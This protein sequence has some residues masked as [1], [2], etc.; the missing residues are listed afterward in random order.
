VPPT[1]LPFTSLAP[2]QTRHLPTRLVNM[3]SP[4]QEQGLSLPQEGEKLR[5]LGDVAS[6]NKDPRVQKALKRL[7]AAKAPTSLSQLVMWRV[8]TDLDWSAIAELSQ[9]WANR[10]ELAMAKDFVDHLDGLTDGEAGRLLLEVQ[11]TDAASNAMAT[12]FTAAL[13]GKMVLG[14]VTTIGIPE[15]PAGPAL[16][17]RVKLTATEASVQVTG[18]DRTARN[19]VAF[20]KFTQPTVV[21]NGKLDQVKLADSLAE[22]ILNRVVRA[23]VIKGSAQKDKGKLVYQIRI[24]NASPLILNGVAFVGTASAPDEMPKLLSGIAIPPGRSMLVPTP[25]ESVK[26]L[27]LKKGIKVL[28]LDLSGL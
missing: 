13:Q 1:G 18:S 21:E 12:E 4:D 22:G 19:W 26:T 9:N 6:V 5:I 7:S 14:L 8:A 24:E 3:S 10:Y 20:G 11:G 16:A 2:G 27:G 23:Q 17:C 28:A 15:R 25:E